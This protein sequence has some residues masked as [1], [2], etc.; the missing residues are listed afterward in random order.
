MVS[1]SIVKE[2]DLIEEKRVDYFST[3]NNNIFNW[4][5]LNIK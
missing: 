2:V 5:H 3:S 1:V 4:N